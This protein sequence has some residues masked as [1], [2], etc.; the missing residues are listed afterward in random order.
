MLPPSFGPAFC[1]LSLVAQL[2][3]T[4]TL[5][6][7]TRRVF[8]GWQHRWQ[9]WELP[10]SFLEERPKELGQKWSK[11]FPWQTIARPINEKSRCE[12]Q[13][14]EWHG[15]VNHLKWT[16]ACSF[17]RSRE[18]SLDLDPFG[19]SEPIHWKSS[20]TDGRVSFN[21]FF[22]KETRPTSWSSRINAIE[23]G[24]HWALKPSKNCFVI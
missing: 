6:R 8:V 7:T 24:P 20:S 13:V 18:Y 12:L 5:G 10:R 11:K 23:S 16:K 19:T 17:V 15:L 3:P 4:T 21:D 14:Y 22:D 1:L 2:V 9:R